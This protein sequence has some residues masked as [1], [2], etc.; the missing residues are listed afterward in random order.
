VVAA[1]AAMLGCSDDVETAARL[2]NLAA[3]VTVRKIHTTGTATPAELRE[4]GSNADYVF[5]PELAE[6]P[7]FARFLPDSEI[8]VIREKPVFTIRHAIFDHDGTLST[9]RQGWEK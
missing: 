1:L 6:S 7:R 9:L 4:I 2:A 3:S 5:E 8:E